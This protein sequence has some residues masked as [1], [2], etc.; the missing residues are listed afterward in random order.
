M[1]NASQRGESKGSE[2]KRLSLCKRL[3]VIP[4]ALFVRLWLRTLRMPCPEEERNALEDRSEGTVIVLWHNRIGV[5]AE[6]ARRF[7]P[8]RAIHCLVSASRDGAWLETFFRAVGLSVVRGSRK[9][10]GTQAVRDLAQKIK[11]GHDV[12][13][14]PDGSKGPCY[15]AKAGALLLA[16]ITKAPIILLSFEFSAAWRL[17]TWD[18]FYLPKPFSRVLVRGKRLDGEFFKEKET[19]EAVACVER[20]LMNLTTDSI[21]PPARARFR[22]E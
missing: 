6:Y 9:S 3:L 2:T 11:Q 19:E 7:R 18:G 22:A 14:T 12:G 1:T 8:Q 10:R 13:I 4:M 21:E 20:E 16:K 17:N 5:S 15:E